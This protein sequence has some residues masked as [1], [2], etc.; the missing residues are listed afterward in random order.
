M[1]TENVAELIKKELEIPSNYQIAANRQL[2]DIPGVDSMSIVNIEVAIS[3]VSGVK[4]EALSIDLNDTV[5]GLAEKV[6]R[7]S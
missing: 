4:A 6:A 3:N 1:T 5:A 2:K 7:M